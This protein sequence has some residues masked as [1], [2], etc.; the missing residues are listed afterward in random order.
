MFNLFASSLCFIVNTTLAMV[1][2]KI[3]NALIQAA[4]CTLLNHNNEVKNWVIYNWT[5][6]W[7]TS[8]CNDSFKL[9]EISDYPRLMVTC[10][11]LTHIRLLLRFSIICE[12]WSSKP[13]WLLSFSQS[14]IIIMATANEPWNTET[15]KM[16]QN[17][18]IMTERHHLLTRLKWA[19]V[20]QEVSLDDWQQQKT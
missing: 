3:F 6:P 18:L 19:S 4:T 10:T 16:D 12:L 2:L 7:P 17:L 20:S 8:T 15:K 11:F 1:V 9:S 14:S 5:W 13:N